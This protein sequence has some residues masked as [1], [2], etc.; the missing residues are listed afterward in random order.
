MKYTR[1]PLAVGVVYTAD[2]N[3]KPKTIIVNGEK[4]LIDKVL[5]KKNYCPKSVAA[6]APIEFTVMVA[7]ETKK[8]YFEK[9]TDKWFSI[10]RVLKENEAQSY[11]TQ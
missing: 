5:Y 11:F 6:I 8:I 2:G 9:D 4:F 10:K 3:F 1:I 7:G